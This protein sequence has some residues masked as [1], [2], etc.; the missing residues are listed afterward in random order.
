MARS[1]LPGGGW[2]QLQTI[3]VEVRFRGVRDIWSFRSEVTVRVAG[4]SFTAVYD[5]LDNCLGGSCTT[6]DRLLEALQGCRLLAERKPGATVT[7]Y[8]AEEVV[9]R[10]YSCPRSLVER[11]LARRSSLV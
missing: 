10:L 7:V 4:R 3:L 5:A 6:V 9:E 11:V 1:T 2:P 8:A